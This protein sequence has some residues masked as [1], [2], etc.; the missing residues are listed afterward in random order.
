MVKNFEISD[1]A[2]AKVEKVNIAYTYPLGP[3]K[4]LSLS[5]FLVNVTTERAQKIHKWV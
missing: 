2:M 1:F 3:M 5:Q 4:M